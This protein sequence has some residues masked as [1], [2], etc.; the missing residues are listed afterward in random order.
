MPY[1]CDEGDAAT[2]VVVVSMIADGDVSVFCY[3]HFAVW[4]HTLDGMLNPAPEP[5]P[6]APKARKRASTKAKASGGSEDNPGP[7]TDPETGDE[8]DED[9]ARDLADVDPDAPIPL[10]P[11]EALAPTF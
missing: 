5:P 6:A 7:A 11:V 2:P 10:K 4:V 8:T 3:E 1:E 9:A